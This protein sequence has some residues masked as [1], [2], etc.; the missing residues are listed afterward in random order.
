MTDAD[1]LDCVVCGNWLDHRWRACPTC[2]A[3]LAPAD[4]IDRIERVAACT[5][6]IA[7]GALALGALLPWATTRVAA[8]GSQTRWGMD[9]GR[10]VA[11][12]ILGLGVMVLG[13]FSLRGRRFAGS[14]AILAIAGMLAL[15]FAFF[16]RSLITDHITELQFQLTTVRGL[17]P[18]QVAA[19]RAT[20]SF[21]AGLWVIAV[22]GLV[23]IVAAAVLPKQAAPRQSTA[24]QFV[25]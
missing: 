8:T 13:L 17:T 20:S 5:A 1:D 14:R 6:V 2:G 7:G 9:G 16:Q 10:G 11:A 23:A 24:P 18:S 22:A 19:Q 12:L 4:R 3:R 25:A 15:G 21:G